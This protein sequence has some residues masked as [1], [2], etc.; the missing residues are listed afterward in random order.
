MVTANV[1]VP[2]RIANG[3]VGYVVGVQY[4]PGTTFEPITVTRGST[5]QI[6]RASQPVECVYV[7]VPGEH[8]AAPDEDR[9]PGVPPGYG[10]DVFPLLPL[11]RSSALVKLPNTSF[12]VSITQVPILPAYAITVHKS[13]GET[14]DAAI[15]G[16]LRGPSA[17]RC[18]PKTSL[19]VAASRVRTSDRLFFA[20][21]PSD[22][23]LDYFKS[24]RSLADEISRLEEKAS[25]TRDAWAAEELRL[26]RS[27]AE[28]DRHG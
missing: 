17:I 15:I 5:A 8:F 12:T 13:Q 4:A 20:W 23:D 19:Y 18:P 6:L 21:E 22:E 28:E 2:L 16:P 25:D 3:T 11:L 1:S 24:P 10:A 14:L 27:W 7:R 26:E 9:L